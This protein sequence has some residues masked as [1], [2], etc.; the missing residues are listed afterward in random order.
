MLKVKK[1]PNDVTLYYGQAS[2]PGT[3]ERVIIANPPAGFWDSW[4]KTYSISTLD[5]S[6][7]TTVYFVQIAYE[8]DLD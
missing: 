1:I 5:N 2:A 4:T 6:G 3:S 7:G 8:M